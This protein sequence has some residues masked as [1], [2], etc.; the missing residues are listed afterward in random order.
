FYVLGALWGVPLDQVFAVLGAGSIV[1]GFVLQD[2]LS[3]LVAG[4]FFAFEKPFEIGH[5]FRYRDYVGLVLEMTW[6]AELLLARKR[7]V[8]IIPISVMGKDVVTN[9]ALLDPLHAEHIQVSF[10]YHHP[11][12]QIRRMLLETALATPGVVHDPAPHIRITGYA[13]D[14]FAINYE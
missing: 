8:I 13:Y 12:N 6:R 5:W 7:D 3:S 14:K 10:G 11:P 4:T 1:V 9:Y 2:T